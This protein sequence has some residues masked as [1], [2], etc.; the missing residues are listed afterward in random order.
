MKSDPHYQPDQEE[1][2]PV[3]KYPNPYKDLI[4][5]SETKSTLFNI[6]W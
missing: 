3:D 6:F 2:S 4:T 5:S 1:I